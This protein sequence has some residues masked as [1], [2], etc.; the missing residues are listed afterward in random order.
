MNISPF[1]DKLDCILISKRNPNAFMHILNEI[2]IN[3]LAHVEMRSC[4]VALFAQGSL[5]DFY[6]EKVDKMLM[7]S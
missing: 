4:V 3:E 2:S 5:E 1:I 7:S 6:V